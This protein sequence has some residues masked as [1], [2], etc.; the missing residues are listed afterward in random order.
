MINP[1]GPSTQNGAKMVLVNVGRAKIAEVLGTEMRPLNIEKENLSLFFLPEK[2][3]LESFMDIIKKFNFKATENQKPTI[4]VWQVPVG[5]KWNSI[6][7]ISAVKD[8][9]SV[10]LLN[11]SD[12]KFI[13]GL[14]KSF[15]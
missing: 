13:D 9:D 12:E 15:A 6:L 5:N 4:K 8:G 10:S 7:G 2:S 3:K 1:I 11:S 14:V